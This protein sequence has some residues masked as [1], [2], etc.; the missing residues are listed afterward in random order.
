MATAISFRHGNTQEHNNFTA[1]VLA[2]ITVDTTEKTLYVHSGDGTKGTPLAKGDLTNV[3]STIFT[4]R[5]GL[6][7]DNL[8]NFN[9]K[10]YSTDIESLGTDIAKY[11]GLVTKD[12]LIGD[13]FAK[14]DMSNVDTVDLATGAGTLNKHKGKN[15]AYSDLSNLSSNAIENNHI[16]KDDLSNITETGT[17]FIQNSIDLSPYDTITDVN[18]KISSVNNNF[19][20]YQLKS[21]KSIDIP[22]FNDNDHYPTSK[23]VSNYV[24]NVLTENVARI[25][26]S[27]IISWD[28]ATASTTTYKYSVQIL[29]VGTG[30]EQGDVIKTGI[31]Y[32]DPNDPSITD[33]VELIVLS[34]AS[35]TII[36]VKTDPNLADKQLDPE[37]TFTDEDPVSS[38]KHGTGASFK[39]TTTVNGEAGNL[40]TRTEAS[41]TYASKSLESTVSTHTSNSTI[42][43]TAANKT[44][45]NNKQNAITLSNK[46]SSDLVDDIDKTNKFVTDT[47]KENW[48]NKVN[49]T[50]ATSKIYATDNTG[51][52]T[53]LSYTDSNTAS[54]VVMRN[55]SSQINIAQTP[56]ANNHAASKKYVDDNTNNK[57][58][59]NAD[60]TGATHTKITYDSKGLVTS[61]AD[62]E[63]SDIPNLT[64]SKIT[65]VTATATEL[66]KLKDLT[67]TK[68]EL[69]YVH[70]VTSAIQNQLNNKQELL[71]G[72][73][74][75][76]VLT[77]SGTKGIVNETALAT[78]AISGSY[79]D[80]SDKPNI[81][82]EQ[83]NADWTA[84]SGKAQILNKPSGI[85]TTASVSSTFDTTATTVPINAAAVDSKNFVAGEKGSSNIRPTKIAVYNTDAEAL[86]ASTENTDWVCFSLGQ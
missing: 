79:N 19:A 41:E 4:N 64:L 14:S 20:N 8:L 22:S 34:V 36:S 11:L 9:G 2:E 62:L 23:A 48:N 37:Y 13:G 86:A 76:T 50:D 18:N 75:N 53:T 28:M 73:T 45:W 39:I 58:I 38:S 47:D 52:Q 67:T 57:V 55:A 71:G 31:T 43:V 80:L 68:T 77:N 24:D 63:A 17:S 35:G 72:G 56:T 65:D 46:L 74:A 29:G 66:N 51:A 1:G 85:L 30:Y 26:L 54:T 42:H 83:V 81:P 44:T 59:K 69:D 15:L 49:Q 70:G 5:F 21:E 84:T 27:N 7:K 33:E 61:G 32:K 10:D 6:L 82:A 3:D 12:E 60:I 25:D 40:L 78:V 16:L